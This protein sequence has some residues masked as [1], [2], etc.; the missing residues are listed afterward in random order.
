MERDSLFS[1][2]KSKE[3]EEQEIVSELVKVRGIM[4]QRVALVN[5]ANEEREARRAKIRSLRQQ[6]VRTN[7][8]D[9]AIVQLVD[10]EKENLEK[11]EKQQIELDEDL[12]KAKTRVD[13]IQDKLAA[14]R[15]EIS[16][17]EKLIDEHNLANL[18]KRT[19][20][21]EVAAEDVT[22]DNR[23]KGRWS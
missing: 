20:V 3:L 6:L 12:S 7:A 18:I 19:A 10:I 2:L 9:P 11:S 4:D 5:K 22:A 13:A 23:T 17:I 16:R 15:V 8:S 1:L 14:A 21:E